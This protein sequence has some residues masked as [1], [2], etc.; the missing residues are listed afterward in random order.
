MRQFQLGNWDT[1]MLYHDGETFGV[2][3]GPRRFGLNAYVTYCSAVD[4]TTPV[5]PYLTIYRWSQVDGSLYGDWRL[6]R[7]RRVLLPGR[8]WFYAAVAAVLAYWWVADMFLHALRVPH[9]H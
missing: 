1:A 5:R 6:L 7:P 9:G 2:S 4:G 8:R 3:V